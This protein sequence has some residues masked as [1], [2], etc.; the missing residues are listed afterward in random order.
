MN[1][2]EKAKIEEAISKLPASGDCG[3]L[4]SHEAKQILESLIKSSPKFE[5]GDRVL[6]YW[7]ST[8]SCS[9]PAVI[10][11]KIEEE[12]YLCGAIKNGFVSQYWM[13][14]IKPDPAHQTIRL[15]KHDG[16][17]ECPV[18]KEIR[19]LVIYDDYTTN[20]YKAEKCNI[21][22]AVKYYAVLPTLE[23]NE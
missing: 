2:Q 17:S 22:Q 23:V 7:E 16:S 14:A 15:I 10:I 5:P 6:V 11:R 18:D 19:I 4:G 3:P 20:T 13:Q 1:D 12:K 9:E 21:W 8:N